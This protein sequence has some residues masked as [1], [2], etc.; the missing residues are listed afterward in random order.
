MADCIEKAGEMCGV[1]GYQMFDQAGKPLSSETQSQA[2]IAALNNNPPKH[3]SDAQQQMFIKCKTTEAPLHMTPAPPPPRVETKPVD[4]KPVDAKSTSP[5]P[6][7]NNAP[8]PL[9]NK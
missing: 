8:I 7:P 1:N 5:S 4:T 2:V 6:A 9:E 3:S